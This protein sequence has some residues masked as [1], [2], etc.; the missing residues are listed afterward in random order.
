L[1]G[2]RGS[3]ENPLLKSEVRSHDAKTATNARPNGHLSFGGRVLQCWSKRGLHIQRAGRNTISAPLSKHFFGAE[4]K[5][6]SYLG[7]VLN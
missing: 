1:T 7:A 5:A 6:L 3:Y 2:N 4:K